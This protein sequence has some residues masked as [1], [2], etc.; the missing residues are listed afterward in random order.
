[1]V[2]SVKNKPVY[3]GRFK[4]KEEAGSERW[5]FDLLYEEKDELF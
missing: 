4:T 3:V 1:V 2:I 5:Y